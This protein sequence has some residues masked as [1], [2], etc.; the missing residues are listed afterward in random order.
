MAGGPQPP[1]GGDARLG[2]S[3]GHLGGQ[4][5]ETSTITTPMAT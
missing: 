5:S 4:A 3:G 2:Q 1:V